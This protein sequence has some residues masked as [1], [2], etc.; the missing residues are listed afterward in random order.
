MEKEERR[1]KGDIIAVYN[2]LLGRGTEDRS[3]VLETH[4]GRT[5]KNRHKLELEKF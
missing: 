4:C 1:Q 5:R 2:Y 3:N